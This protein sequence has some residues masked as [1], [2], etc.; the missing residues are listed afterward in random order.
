MSLQPN[1]P[2]F[3]RSVRCYSRCCYYCCGLL[4]DYSFQLEHICR[5][6]SVGVY[7]FFSTIRERNDKKNNPINKRSGSKLRQ[8]QLVREHKQHAWQVMHTCHDTAKIYS[9]LKKYKCST[10]ERMD[11]MNTSRT[12]A[13]LKILQQKLNTLLFLQ[14]TNK[15]TKK[16]C[17]S[18]RMQ[19]YFQ[20]TNQLWI[21]I[22]KCN[23]QQS[24]NF[25]KTTNTKSLTTCFEFALKNKRIN[26]R[27]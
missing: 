8:F 15:Q 7:R 11:D 12:H 25:S 10:G 9:I 19:I 13:V 3:L 20:K 21:K 16:I 24:A 14:Q 2:S 6:P 17:W 27:S 26:N 22:C 4:R 18:T 1:S 23:N 5:S